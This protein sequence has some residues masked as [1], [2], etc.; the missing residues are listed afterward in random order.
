VGR[1]AVFLASHVIVRNGNGQVKGGFLGFLV[2]N[3][4]D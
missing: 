3:F 2:W 4:G 1:R